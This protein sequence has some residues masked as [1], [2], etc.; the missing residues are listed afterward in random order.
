MAFI[1]CRNLV[2]TYSTKDGRETHA[3]G[4]LS[5]EVLRGEFVSLVGPSGCGKSTL[6]KILGGLNRPSKGECLIK[7][8]VV[9]RPGRDRA[10]VFQE[11]ALFPWRTVLD[12]VSFGLENYRVPREERDARALTLIRRLGLQGFEQRY[13]HELSGGMKQRVGI[14]RALIMEPDVLLMDEPFAALDAQMREILQEELERLLIETQKTVIFVT[15]SIDEALF[16]SDRI[17]VMSARPGQVTL[18]QSLDFARPRAAHDI[19]NSSA[20][21]TA[22]SRIWEMLRAEVLKSQWVPGQTEA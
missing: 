6:L 7:D 4:P 3:L 19:R 8:T 14:A 22:R 9:D 5:L 18:E 15:H 17:I 21:Q 16:L 2:K 20:F 1:E 11:F 10:I 13:P 12:N